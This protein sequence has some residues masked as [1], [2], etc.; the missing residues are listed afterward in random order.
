MFNIADIITAGSDLVGW[1][2]SANVNYTGLASQLKT[3][4]SGYYVN[5]LPGIDFDIINKG[6]SGDDTSV[7]TYLQRV[8]ESEI[9]GLVNEFSVKAK[10]KLGSRAI[11][12]NFDVVNGIADVR[13]LATKNA[14]FVGWL[15]SPRTSNNIKTT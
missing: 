7:N 13:D 11:L 5:D 3:S 15:I 14:R 6:L 9:A 10:S 4:Q 1:R 12:S 2:E 8:H